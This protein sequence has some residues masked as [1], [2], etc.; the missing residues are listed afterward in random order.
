MGVPQTK[1]GLFTYADYYSWDDEER[2][3][4]I[5]GVAYNMSPAPVRRHQQALLSLVRAIAA[6]TDRGPCETYIAPFDVRF[7]ADES[8][9]TVVQPDISVFCDETKLDDRGAVGPPDLV[10]EIL[11]PATSHKDM[12]AKLAL[13]ERHGVREYWI[14]NADAPWVMVYRVGSDRRYAKPDYYR[15]GESVPSE[16][17]GGAEIPLAEVLPRRTG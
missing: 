8:T 5:D 12:T 15:E 13:Y 4:L 11:S 6:V 10:V 16:V 3:E 17:L 14:V 2:W 7:S 9:H 1:E